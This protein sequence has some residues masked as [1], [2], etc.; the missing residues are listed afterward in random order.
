MPRR[1]R[2]GEAKGV[3]AGAASLFETCRFG[4]LGKDQKLTVMRRRR[5]SREEEASA[6]RWGDSVA[7]CEARL[8]LSVLGRAGECAPRSSGEDAAVEFPAVAFEP[9]DH[10]IGGKP[11][12]RDGYG[13]TAAGDQAADDLVGQR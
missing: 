13:G 9:C 8:P 5:R 7:F 2:A 1:S 11:L 12:E 10:A 3:S 6:V 4:V